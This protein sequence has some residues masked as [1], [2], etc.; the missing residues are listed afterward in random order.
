M[1]VVRNKS[2]AG[3][4]FNNF[5]CNLIKFGCV[6]NHFIGYSGQS[7]N[8]IRD[9]HVRPDKGCKGVSYFMSVVLKDG[10]FG[11]L[12]MPVTV[13]CGFYI[14]YCKQNSYKFNLCIKEMYKFVKKKIVILNLI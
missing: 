2:T 12:A 11:D 6:L 9:V 4:H 8:E 13:T 5:T 7:C 14:D 3:C 1:N 10:N